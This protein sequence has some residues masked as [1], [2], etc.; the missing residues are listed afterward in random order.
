MCSSDYVFVEGITIKGQVV[1]LLG[2]AGE[3]NYSGSQAQL[4]ENAN[5]NY[6]KAIND[7]DDGKGDLNKT[8]AYLRE[9]IRLYTEA[10]RL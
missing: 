1:G 5:R 7:Y 6:G 9:A 3:Q 2:M 8:Q 10:L 4:I